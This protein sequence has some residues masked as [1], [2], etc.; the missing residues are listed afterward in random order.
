M[1]KTLQIQLWIL[2]CSHTALLEYQEQRKKKLHDDMQDGLLLLSQLKQDLT[3][4]EKV[5]LTRRKSR[6]NA[7]TVS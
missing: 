6:T 1:K 7:V 5:V 3:K 4:M 2:F